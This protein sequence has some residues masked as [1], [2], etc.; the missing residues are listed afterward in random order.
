MFPMLGLKASS[1]PR[2]IMDRLKHQPAVFEFFTDQPDFTP[3]GLTHLKQMI[4]QVQNQGISQIVLHQ[5]MNFQGHH[6]EVITPQDQFPALYDFVH[7]TAVTLIQVAKETGTQALIHGSYDDQHG[8][9]EMLAAY[10]NVAAARQVGFDV[11]DRLQ[12]FGGE[13]V[14]FENSISPVFFYGD[15]A[16]E[17]AILAHDYRLAYDVSHAFITVHGDNDRLITS[18]EHLKEQIVHYHLVDSMGQ[19]H[20]SLPLGEGRIAWPRVLPHLNPAATDIY[21]IDLKDQANC[22]EQVASHQYLQQFM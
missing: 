18:L 2:Q 10:P 14:L 22:A 13:H 1:D 5:P 16:V 15:P 20:D 12:E 3:S 9:D 19:T 11:L 7:R 4:G 8:F 21:E 17:D 6:T